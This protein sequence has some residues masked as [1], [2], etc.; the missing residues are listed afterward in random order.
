MELRP[1]IVEWNPDNPS[2]D[3]ATELRICSVSKYHE[4]KSLYVDS[5]EALSRSLTFITGLSNLALCG[6]HDT[7]PV[8]PTIKKFAPSSMAEFHGLSHAPKPAM[9]ASDPIFG[10][11]IDGMIDPALRNAIGHNTLELDEVTEIMTYDHGRNP[12]QEEDITYG[13]FH[14]RILRT[15]YRS[16]QA[17]QIIKMIL[18]FNEMM[19]AS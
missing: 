8:H 3:I 9:V 15:L 12:L 17:N 1:A 13:Q 10:P 5:Y 19:S 11:W 4:L 6:N 18:Y 14:C 7:Y 16:H 2:R